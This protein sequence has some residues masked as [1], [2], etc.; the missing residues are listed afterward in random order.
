VDKGLARIIWDS[1]SAPASWQMRSELWGDQR[2]VAAHPELV[3][4]VVDAFVAN[5]RWA[6]DPVNRANLLRMN[7]ASGI[8]ES[9]VRRDYDNLGDDWRG[10][11]SPR[12]DAALSEHYR[13]AAAY[14]LK[15]AL[16]ADP[17]DIVGSFEPRFVEAALARQKLQDY[18]RADDGA[19][20][21]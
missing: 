2:F 5:A 6:S 8:P 19:A 12:F 9:V 18:W 17:V 15:S 20:K 1:K 3:Q 4:L 7:A 10:R 13:G 21:R 16:I 14:A 11:F